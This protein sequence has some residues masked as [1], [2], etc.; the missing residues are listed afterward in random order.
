MIGSVVISC[1]LDSSS[2]KEHLTWPCS[3][4]L[5]L[6]NTPAR[7]GHTLGLQPIRPHKS[8]LP[9]TLLVIP[10]LAL[11]KPAALHAIGLYCRSAGPWPGSNMV[12]LE[13]LSSAAGC[14]TEAEGN[15]APV[16]GGAG[17]AAVRYFLWH[18]S[19]S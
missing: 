8:G 14:C 3:S 18:S 9:K 4:F 11:G 7:A 6:W 12:T 16:P 19:L 13:G 1:C 10:K 2:L 5:F 17:L 15:V